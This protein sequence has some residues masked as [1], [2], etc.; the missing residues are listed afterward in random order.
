MT[1]EI[2]RW[3]NPS[4]SGAFCYES[5]T[6]LRWIKSES[7]FLIQCAYSY[8]FN[9]STVEKKRLHANS[10]KNYF[11]FCLNQRGESD[12]RCEADLTMETVSKMAGDTREYDVHFKISNPKNIQNL[13]KK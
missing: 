9:W 11:T 3:L 2:K 7:S 13:L 5:L 12:A 8:Q 10:I 1:Q 6:T 4:T